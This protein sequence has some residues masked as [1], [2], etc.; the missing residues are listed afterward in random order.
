MAR[1]DADRR[2]GSRAALINLD[3][4]LGWWRLI[5]TA[6]PR[7]MILRFIL[8]NQSLLPAQTVKP[9]SEDQ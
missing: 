1:Q 3:D 5:C 6:D 2:D 9:G 4:G 7:I 8:K